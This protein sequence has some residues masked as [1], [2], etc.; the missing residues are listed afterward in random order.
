MYQRAD[1][2]HLPDSRISFDIISAMNALLDLLPAVLFF[3]A[4]WLRGLYT[5]TA[6][7]IVACC[8]TLLVTWLRTRRVPRMQLVT[9][10]LAIVFGGLTL[11]LHN[12]AFIKLKFKV[13]SVGL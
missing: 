10:I 3:T 9:A 5:A 8:S 13:A 6:V 1:R 7:L 11:W 2:R 12:P 4:Y